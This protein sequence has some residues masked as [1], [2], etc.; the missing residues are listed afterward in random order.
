MDESYPPL[1]GR[2]WQTPAQESTLMTVDVGHAAI[3]MVQNPSQFVP[4]IP[5][6]PGPAAGQL[7]SS[8]PRDPAERA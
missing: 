8:S 5:S 3:P 2:R 1:S 6:P 4:Q 7:I